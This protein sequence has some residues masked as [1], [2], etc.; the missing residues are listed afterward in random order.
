MMKE[1]CSLSRDPGPWW[2]CHQ[3]YLFGDWYYQP[4]DPIISFRRAIA[5]SKQPVLVNEI[6]SLLTSKSTKLICHFLNDREETTRFSLVWFSVPIPVYWWM[7]SVPKTFLYRSGH[8]N[9]SREKQ[10]WI[11]VYRMSQIVHTWSPLNWLTIMVTLFMHPSR[12]RL[13]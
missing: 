12:K 7:N 6:H 10:C 9:L 1:H 4:L 8:W 3:H 2:I 13:Y 5:Q 11:K